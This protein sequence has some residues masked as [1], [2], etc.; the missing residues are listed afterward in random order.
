M[1]S[2]RVEA[3]I[4]Q[5]ACLCGKLNLATNLRSIKGERLF[6][7]PTTGFAYYENNIFGHR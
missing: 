4:R 1:A 5:G 7:E 3:A 6:G 2:S